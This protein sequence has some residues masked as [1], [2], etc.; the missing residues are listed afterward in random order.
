MHE[1]WRIILSMFIGTIVMGL[2]LYPL[3]PVSYW[4]SR[5]WVGAA[6]GNFLG[7]CGGVVWFLRSVK[8][9]PAGTSIIFLFVGIFILIGTSIGLFVMLPFI[10]G[11]EDNL[12][13]IHSLSNRNITHVS[14]NFQGRQPY[15]I[16]E[17]EE[18]ASFKKILSNARLFGERSHEISIIEDI[19]IEIQCDNNRIVYNANIPEKHQKDIALE[20]KVD[21][22]IF[23]LQNEILLIG[24]KEWLDQ[25]T[26]KNEE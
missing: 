21:V 16:T 19:K 20:Y 25:I 7:F 18:I 4:F 12:N 1:Y 3:L 23:K 11:Q 13:L 26:L 17:P 5:Y 10:Q 14:I 6:I 24:L 15:I 8:P 9:I 2:L 22:R